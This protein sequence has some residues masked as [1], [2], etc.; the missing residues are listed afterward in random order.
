M[1]ESQRRR[2]NRVM[3]GALVA[4]A[5]VLAQVVAP[6]AQSVPNPTVIGPIPA[7]AIAGDLSR[8]YPFFASNIDLASRGFVEEEYFLEGTA[9]TYDVTPGVLKLDTAVVTS[10]GN[11]YRTRMIVRRPV[12]AGDFNGTVIMEWQNVTGGYEPDALWLASHDHLIRRGY[13]WIGVSAQR[14]GVYTP[15][16]GL[17]AW[18]PTR[19]GTL[20]MTGAGDA[21]SWDI[22]SQAAQAV[23]HP[24][25]VDPMGGLNVDRVFAV[26][27]SQSAVRL[28]SYHNSIHPL[29]GVFD[30]FALVG[31]DGKALLPLRTDLDVKVF[32]LLSETNV[33]GNSIAISQALLRGQEPNTDHFRR[34]EVAGAAH[35]GY[36]EFE[37]ALPLQARD[38]LPAVP[39]AC[40]AP[41]LSR[42][43]MHFAVNAAYDHLV[44]WVRHNVAPPIADDIDVESMGAQV[45]VI[46]RD[47]FGN[48]LGGIRLSQLAVPTASNTGLNTP[49]APTGYCRYVGSYIPFDSATLDALY[50]THQAYLGLVIAATHESLNRGF[51][52]GADAAAT[53]REAAKSDVG[54]Q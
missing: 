51:I 42:I 46:A 41:P 40:D 3:K 14:A 4:G 24:Q 20:S 27:W 50:P 22:F 9:N 52:D 17:R 49:V 45:S 30:G 19:Y 37:E 43:P 33:A 34:W 48:A 15:A 5:F 10:S 1:A 31:S 11:P 36:H 13:A 39:L 18:S 44:D 38:G 23:R 2:E 32:K 53:L 16:L 12:S 7:T 47:S 26:G 35:L 28:V 8:A 25:A 21:L 6:G 29:A 54:R